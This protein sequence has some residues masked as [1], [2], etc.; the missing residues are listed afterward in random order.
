MIENKKKKNTVKGQLPG[1]CEDGLW[2]KYLVN[3]TANKNRLSSANFLKS[4]KIRL[5]SAFCPLGV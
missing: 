2:P 5:N 3:K 4:L 1:V